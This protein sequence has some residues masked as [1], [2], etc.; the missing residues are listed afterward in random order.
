MAHHVRGRMR[1]FGLLAALVVALVVPATVFADEPG[2]PGIEP[3]ASQGATADIEGVTLNSRL[4]AT[5]NVAVVCDELTYFNWETWEEYTT[6]D[7]VVYA[8]GQLLQ[9]QGRSIASASGFARRAAV[10]CDGSTVNHVA[11]QVIAESLPLRRG[12]ALVGVSLSVYAS[13]GEGDGAYASS[14]P[15]AVKLGK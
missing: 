11:V 5:I 6:T 10:T 14:G 9:A 8:G 3:W 12:D 1:A 7:G 4:M 15:V 13:G 2:G